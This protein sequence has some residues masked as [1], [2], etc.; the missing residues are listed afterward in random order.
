MYLKSREPLRVLVAVAYEDLVP[1]RFD[2][3]YKYLASKTALT[4]QNLKI[5]FI[6]LL[7]QRL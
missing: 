7:L 3:L 4:P 2:H 5:N 1:L 6:G